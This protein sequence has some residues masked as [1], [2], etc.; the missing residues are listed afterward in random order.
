MGTLH[1]TVLS[2]G[3]WT[4]IDRLDLLP[5]QPFSGLGRDKLRAVVTADIRRR[6]LGAHRLT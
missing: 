6:A 5:F 2:G 3:T 4:D 1:I